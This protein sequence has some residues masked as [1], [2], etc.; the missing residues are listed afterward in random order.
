MVRC[1]RANPRTYSI[2]YPRCA[3][4]QPRGGAGRPAPKRQDHPGA[5]L[6]LLLFHGGRRIGIELKRADAPLVTKSM[7]IALTDLRLD[8]LLVLYP[9]KLAY[10]LAERVDVLP[11]SA[12]AEWTP[13]TRL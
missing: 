5:E 6:D 7:Q 2:P 12:V 4:A 9:G 8:R 13:K 1:L 3:Q 10:A 11:M